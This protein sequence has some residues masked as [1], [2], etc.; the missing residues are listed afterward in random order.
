LKNEWRKFNR[1]FK[2]SSSAKIAALGIFAVLLSLFSDILADQC[3]AL[4]DRAAAS[5]GVDFSNFLMNSY[6][7]IFAVGVYSRV[8][9]VISGISVLTLEVTTKRKPVKKRNIS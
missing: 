8:F 6:E 7:K 4:A 9:V 3:L 5:F 1:I 2:N